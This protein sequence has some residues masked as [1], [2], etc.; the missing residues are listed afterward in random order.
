MVVP[1]KKTEK[2]GKEQKRSRRMKG[3][4]GSFLAVL[5]KMPIKSP[6]KNV[7]QTVQYMSLELRR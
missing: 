5:F 6:N 3:V 1:L 2:V 7:K 4:H